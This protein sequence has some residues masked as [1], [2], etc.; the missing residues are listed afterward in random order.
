[1]VTDG[2][3]EEADILVRDGRIEQISLSIQAPANA[4]LS[5]LE[6]FW[7]LPGLIDDQVHFREPD[8]PIRHVLP[9]KHLSAKL[10]VTTFF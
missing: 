2:K 3:K 5:K 1:M 9:P 6:A 4:K 10:G 7:I 8:L